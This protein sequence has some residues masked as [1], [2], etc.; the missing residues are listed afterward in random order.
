MH[1]T[2]F[3]TFLAVGYGAMAQDP[4]QPSET[5]TV[6]STPPKEPG[7]SF[8]CQTSEF[9]TLDNSEGICGA[10]GGKFNLF[11]G[12]CIDTAAS[13]TESSYTQ[14]CSDNG[15]TVKKLDSGSCD[16]AA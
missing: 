6:M 10:A 14:G 8:L 13:G 1:F 3:F 4:K 2:T 5:G 16:L 9:K 7:T 12:C 15:G 11:S